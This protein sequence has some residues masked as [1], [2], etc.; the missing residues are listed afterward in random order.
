[1]FVGKKDRLAVDSD[2]AYFSWAF[3]M[4]IASSVGAILDAVVIAVSDTPSS[5][6]TT[7]D[8]T[9]D[10]ATSGETTAQ[11]STR[12]GWWPFCSCF[13]SC[14]TLPGE[15]VSG[16]AL[17]QPEAASHLLLPPGYGQLPQKVGL[18]LP[19]GYGQLPQQAGLYYGLPQFTPPP[20]DAEPDKKPLEV[21]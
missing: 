10:N 1:M 13:C 2:T 17:S 5:D 8:E 16:G 15:M 11:P 6:N 18:G 21:A 3:F 14:K 9:T 4:A 12:R 7:R 20:A 19:P